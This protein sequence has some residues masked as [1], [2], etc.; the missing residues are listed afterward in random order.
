ME[1]FLDVASVK[2]KKEREV[3]DRVKHEILEINKYNV[4]G[5][6]LYALGRPREQ[7]VNE[8]MPVVEMTSPKDGRAKHM[9]R[10]LG[11]QRI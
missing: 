4:G 10:S 8:I 7:L 1:R 2:P 9:P 6:L 5:S 11:S 3:C